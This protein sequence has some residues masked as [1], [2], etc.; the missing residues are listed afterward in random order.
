MRERVVAV[1]Q[2]FG[3]RGGLGNL[4][5]KKKFRLFYQFL[6]NPFEEYYW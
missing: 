4:L 3:T 1:L 5:V 6:L 2:A